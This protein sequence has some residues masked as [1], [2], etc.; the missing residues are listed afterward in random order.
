MLCQSNI[1]PILTY[2]FFDVVPDARCERKNDHIRCTGERV[3][4]FSEGLL[5]TNCL[6]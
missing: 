3:S 2:E 6:V 5:M 1:S 4:V